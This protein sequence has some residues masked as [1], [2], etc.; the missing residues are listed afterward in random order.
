[1]ST[2]GD[3]KINIEYLMHASFRI[4][5]IPFGPFQNAQI[6][7]SSHAILL[8]RRAGRGFKLQREIMLFI[9]KPRGRSIMISNVQIAFHNTIFG[10]GPPR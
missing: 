10:R 8:T 4:S 3:K 1:M 7:L 5:G 2:L 6:N 9:G